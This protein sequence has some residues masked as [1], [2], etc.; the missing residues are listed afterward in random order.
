MTR[1]PKRFSLHPWAPT[2][3]HVLELNKCDWINYKNECIDPTDLCLCVTVWTGRDAV[4]APPLV[5][6]P[7]L[8]REHYRIYDCANC[9]KNWT[10]K[11]YTLDVHVK[12]LY[13]ILW[14][15]VCNYVPIHTQVRYN[16]KT[17]VQQNKYQNKL[18]WAIIYPAQCAT[19][20]TNSSAL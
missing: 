6:Q 16:M 3:E 14:V 2:C 12:I 18:K 19:I 11:C 20:N 8:T 17:Q 4:C 5:L 7:N 15:Y 13:F 10:Q 9:L 1:R